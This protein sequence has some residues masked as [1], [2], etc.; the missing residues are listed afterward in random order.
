MRRAFR[1]VALF[2]LVAGI[3]FQGVALAAQVSAMAGLG[4]ASHAALHADAVAHH[5]DVDGS[6]HED[7]SPKSL[8][9]VQH[10][11]CS[12]FAGVLPQVSLQVPPAGASASLVPAA[13][14]AH[15]SAFLEGLRRPPR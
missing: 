10:D 14:A 5:H 7:Q 13:D 11:C 3:G 9:H 2:W 8:Q 6:V 12:Q 15:A 4:D 1:I